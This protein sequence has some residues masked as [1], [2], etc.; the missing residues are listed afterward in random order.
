MKSLSKRRCIQL[1]MEA[2]G[3]MLKA[4]LDSE[5]EINLISRAMVKQLKL[6]PFLINEKACGIANTKLKTFGIHFLTV[7]VID[8]NGN[9]RFFEEF[10][11]KVSINEDLI[12]GMSWLE[13]ATSNVDW[14]NHIIKWSLDSVF[15]MPTARRLEIINEKLMMDDLLVGDF[16]AYVLHVRIHKENAKNLRN[17]HKFRK[18]RISVALQNKKIEEKIEIAISKEWQHIKEPFR[19]D[20]I[21][22]LPKHESSDHAIDL[23]EKTQLSY[24]FIYSLSKL[25][26]K[27]FKAY[28]EK[29]LANNFIR[30]FKSST[31]APILFVKKKDGSLRLC[32]N[33]R[34]LNSLTIK[35]RYLLSLIEKSL[36]RLSRTIIYSKFDITSAYHRMRIKK[37]NEWKTAF[38]TRYG[39]YKYQ[40]LFFDLT[41]APIFF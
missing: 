30:S 4:L 40:V 41:N 21:Y 6:P 31:D 29:H 2:K 22:E 16:V 39:Y 37:E 24:G 28:I 8:K 5:S 23:E 13:L 33:Y 11:L 1:E 7:A 32:V 3:K 36:D 12:F 19:K 15:I 10:F 20:L 17:V 9:Q 25:K 27:V 26:L 35:N 18:T 38:R 34:D 14:R